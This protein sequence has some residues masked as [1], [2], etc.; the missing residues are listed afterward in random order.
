MQL[1]FLEASHDDTSTMLTQIHEFK[2]FLTQQTSSSGKDPC[3]LVYKRA[4]ITT[5][6]HTAKAYAA[7]FRNK[8]ACSAALE[9]NA[10]PQVF[11]PSNG[12]R[13]R[14]AKTKTGIE[15]IFVQTKKQ[16]KS[17]V[18]KNIHTGLRQILKEAEDILAEKDV[19]IDCSPPCSQELPQEN[20]P[21][22]VLLAALGV[23]KCYGYKKEIL[24]KIASPPKDLVFCMQVKGTNRMAKMLW[25]CL[26]LLNNIM[27]SVTQP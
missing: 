22:V 23:R 18:N 20:F 21:E 1:W 5:Q 13:H 10:N 19:S 3:S 27:C 16:K 9:E 12:A 24:N 15:G 26:F 2:S 7:E 14:P 25:K 4:N 6:I 11:V 8:N 17:S